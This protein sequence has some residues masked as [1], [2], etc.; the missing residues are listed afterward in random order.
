M[1]PLVQT[2]SIG[3]QQ[4]TNPFAEFSDLLTTMGID[5]EAA[6]VSAVDASSI[7]DLTNSVQAAG[8]CYWGSGSGRTMWFQGNKGTKISLKNKPNTSSCND[9]NLHIEVKKPHANGCH[10]NVLIF[11][12][13]ELTFMKDVRKNKWFE[14]VKHLH[15]NWDGLIWVSSKCGLAR[16]FWA[17]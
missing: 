1:L 16:V 14:P 9:I 10:A 12:N 8:S 17:S 4:T 13:D 15:T 2:G 7:E 5:A 6:S 11:A 3:E